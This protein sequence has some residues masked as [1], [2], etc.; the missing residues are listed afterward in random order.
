[1]Q[2]LQEGLDCSGSNG[3]AAGGSNGM[4]AGAR[5]AWQLVPEWQEH[6][7]VADVTV[8]LPMSTLQLWPWSC[9]LGC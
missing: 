3:M 2:W 9:W 6:P 8:E 4:A 1:M 7:Y 5:V